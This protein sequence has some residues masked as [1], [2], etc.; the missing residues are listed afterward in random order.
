MKFHV[1]NRTGFILI[2]ACA[3]CLC[4]CK[5][6]KPNVVSSVIVSG[7]MPNIAKD[8]LG[9]IHMVYG[10]GDSILY[11]YSSNMG[12]TFSAPTLIA[13]LSKL[14]ASH[15]RGPQI[16]ATTNG[17]A[18]TAC[19]DLGDIFSSPGVNQAHGHKRAE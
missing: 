15:T 13:V 19:N 7:Q 2:F 5:D 12:K 1:S 14:A 17:L 8:T 10:N 9:N 4:A 18:V 11:S 3:I 6:E 16:A